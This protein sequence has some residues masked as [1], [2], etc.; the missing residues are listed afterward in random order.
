MNLNEE[1]QKEPILFCSKV[2]IMKKKV[3]DSFDIMD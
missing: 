3:R 2:I 1:D